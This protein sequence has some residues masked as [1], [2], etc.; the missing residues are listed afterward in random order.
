MNCAEFRNLIHDLAR[1]DASADAAV[2]GALAHAESCRACDALLREAEQ[3]TAG[4]RSLAAQHKFDAAPPTVEAA[5]LYAF[6]Q[7]H[8]PAPRLRRV[9]GWLAVSTVGLAAAALCAILLTGYRPGKSPASPGG[10]ES[11][12][13]QTNR[14]AT[15]PRVTWA[16]YAVDGETEE[17]AAA[18]YVPLAADFDP[19]WLEAGAI[20]RVVLSRPALES[21]G[22]AVN[23][24]DSQVLADMVITND[25]TPQAIRFV[26][27]QEANIQ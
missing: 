6:R 18:S 9:G 19:S 24:D 25:G 5:L 20:V 14:P 8:A 10:P 3:L 16:E 21:L 23:A 27:W 1:E 17:Q 11:A 15:A 26:D 2:A 7:H 22:V 13:R 4:L 12:P